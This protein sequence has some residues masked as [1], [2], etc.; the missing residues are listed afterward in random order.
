M[1]KPF[2]LN[3]AGDSGAKI[4]F[5]IRQAPDHFQQALPHLFLEPL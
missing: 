5:V 4:R 2:H 1:E 3:L